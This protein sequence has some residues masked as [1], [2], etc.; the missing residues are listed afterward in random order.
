M[1]GDKWKWEQDNPKYMV[2]GRKEVLKGKFIAI[3]A[4]LRKQEKSQ[5]NN[6]TLWLK[7][8]EKEEQT[9]PKVGRRKEIIQISVDI[10][11]IETKQK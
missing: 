8:Q 9:K 2:C 10:D 7:E 3:T 4:Y 5:P 1:P 6:L 11:D